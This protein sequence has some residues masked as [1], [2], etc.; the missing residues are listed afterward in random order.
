LESVV[1]VLLQDVNTHATEIYRRGLFVLVACLSV[2]ELARTV[3]TDGGL[4]PFGVD[5]SH[6]VANREP[7]GAEVVVVSE[8]LNLL[9]TWHKLTYDGVEL[10]RLLVVFTNSGYDEVI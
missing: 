7:A 2:S 5:R 6:G 3:C 8:Y 9:A 4:V 10:I 1:K